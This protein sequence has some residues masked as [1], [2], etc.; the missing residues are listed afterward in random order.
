[1]TLKK[2]GIISSV[3]VSILVVITIVLSCVK[4][5]CGLMLSAPSK[6][7]LYNETSVSI[8]LTEK[9]N[10]GDFKKMN[11]LY[12]QM[13]NL[14]II[15][16]MVN[17]KAIKSKPGQDL[18]DKYSR[19]IGTNKSENVCLELIYDDKQTIIV[20][21]D[22]DTKIIEFYGLIMIVNNNVIGSEVAIYFST[23]ES[24][25][26]SYSQ[27]PILVNAKQNKLYKFIQEVSNKLADK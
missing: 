7:L 26:K 27:N 23:S 2:F 1:M 10:P 5:N 25:T 15:N 21:V 12:N 18:D 3:I 11:E 22:G 4:V 6:F 8:A 14:S 17:N 13:T 24:E 19:W 20:E 16:Y 9:N